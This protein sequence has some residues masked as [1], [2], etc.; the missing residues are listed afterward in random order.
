MI[1]LS[2]RPSTIAATPDPTYRNSES[3]PPLSLP[4]QARPGHV[5]MSVRSRK[6]ATQ[7]D[8]GVQNQQSSTHVPSGARV[9]APLPA[10]KTNK[11]PPPEKATDVRRRS[12]VILSFWA[13]ILSVGLP[14]WWHTTSVYR[15]SLPLDE[16]MDWA[17]GRVCKLLTCT[18]LLQVDLGYDS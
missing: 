10:N 4:T 3:L 14:I 8:L 9:A 16:M 17:D 1:K 2:S 5:A 18:A 7:L 12:Y 6:P 13:L 15:A 11:D